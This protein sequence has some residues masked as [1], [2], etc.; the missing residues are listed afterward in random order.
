MVAYSDKAVAEM[1]GG[2][3][4]NLSQAFEDK[5][6]NI[7]LAQSDTINLSRFGNDR[8]NSTAR[9]GDVVTGDASTGE[10]Y[11]TAKIFLKSLKQLEE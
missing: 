3:S 4:E 11:K 1:L 7:S 5:K 2:I 8:D 9:G 10:L 6:V